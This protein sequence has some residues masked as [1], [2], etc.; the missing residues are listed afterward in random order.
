MI[1]LISAPDEFPM[2]KI[3]A[4]PSFGVEYFKS[5]LLTIDEDLLHQKQVDLFLVLGLD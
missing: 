3:E 5:T 4:K 1:I 2:A